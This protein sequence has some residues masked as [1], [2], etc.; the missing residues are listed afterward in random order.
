VGTEGPRSRE[1]A[2]EL[3]WCNEASKVKSDAARARR[4]MM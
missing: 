1:L 4:Q 2:A 3:R